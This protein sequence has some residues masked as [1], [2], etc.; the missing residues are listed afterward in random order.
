LFTLASRPASPPHFSQFLAGF[1]A[2]VIDYV[3]QRFIHKHPHLRSRLA[4]GCERISQALA[5]IRFCLQGCAIGLIGGAM[6]IACCPER[7]LTRL[8][9]FLNSRARIFAKRTDHVLSWRR[10]MPLPPSRPV[11]SERY[12]GDDQADEE[13]IDG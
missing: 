8:H 5:V 11:G 1:R 9:D 7:W 12:C 4:P 2:N 13:Q 6:R 3:Y 10:R